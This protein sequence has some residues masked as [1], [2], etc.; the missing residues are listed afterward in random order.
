MSFKK[1][2]IISS[3]AE[4]CGNAA[5]TKI[6]HDSIEQ[7][8][9]NIQVEVIELDLPLLQ[10]IDKNVR[11]KAEL[12]IDDI[13]QQ[14]KSFD[15]VNI[16][17][18]AGLYGTLPSDIVKRFSKIVSVN[19][20]TTVTLHSP[21]IVSSSQSTTRA[22]IKKLLTFKIKSGLKDIIGD[23]LSQIHIRINKKIVTACIKNNAKIIVHT[24]RAKKQLDRFF[25]YKNV[26]VHPLKMVPSTYRSSNT[27]L[28]DIKSQTKIEENAVII[29]MFGYLSAYKGHTDALDALK[30]LPANYKLFIFGRQHPQTL[31]SNGI[32][33]QYLD[34]LI[35][36]VIKSDELKNRVFFLGELNDQDF[37]D[38]A[39]NVDISW[40]PYYEN[41][42]D[43]SG[44]ASICLELSPR[45]LCSS[46]FAFDELFKLIKYR[47]S[48][49]FDIGNIAEMALKTKM[50]MNMEKIEYPY[51]INN[52]FSI[53][54]QA[55]IYCQT[56]EN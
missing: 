43:G 27:T 1:L 52:D 16:Q 30:L 20:N 46:S 13:C 22:G 31:K 32:V 10:S 29:G 34:K 47:N 5:F 33:D 19:K 28:D 24:L 54:T 17:M 51:E 11:K 12:H 14:L 8:H 48:M 56:I 23:Q 50:M 55:N 7:T 38:V 42:Q 53:E 41:G 35:K 6:L 18:E 40:L 3:Y 36:K 21:R 4:S 37:L 25:S 39:S 9:S 45:V 15:C 2:A 44:I 26:A 49:R